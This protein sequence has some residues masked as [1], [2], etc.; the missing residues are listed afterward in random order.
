MAAAEVRWFRH[1]YVIRHMAFNSFADNAPNITP[2]SLSIK[3]QGY[4]G[5]SNVQPALTSGSILYVQSQ[6]S[7]I[8]EFSYNAAGSTCEQAAQ[9]R[10]ELS[11]SRTLDMKVT[12]CA[13]SYNAAVSACEQ[14]AQRALFADPHAGHRLRLQHRHQRRAAGNDRPADDSKSAPCDAGLQPRRAALR[15][16]RPHDVPR[17]FP[18]RGHL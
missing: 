6:G 14:G 3:P 18:A 7:R 2:T 16:H 11:R 13:I 1:R 8:R 4:T 12:P 17:A 9:W 5:A 10:L 15:D